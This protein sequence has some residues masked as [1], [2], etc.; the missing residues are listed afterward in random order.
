[1]RTW[2]E[3]E[4]LLKR[5]RDWLGRTD[6]EIQ[7][8]RDESDD[9]QD[10]SDGDLPEVGLVQLIEAF[11]ALR[12]EL[13]LQTKSS[14]GLEEAIEQAL[15]GIDEAAEQVRAFQARE[16]GEAERLARP[17]A[18]ALI[19]L[20]EALERGLRAA[21]SAQ[22]DVVQDAVGRF[23]QASQQ[24]LH[25][26]SAWQRWKARAWSDQ[27][28]ELFREQA[29]DLQRR[30]MLPLLEGYRLIYER[31]ERTLAEL[32]I[33]RIPCVGQSVD[34]M[35]MTVVELVDSA[36]A[37]PETVV[38]QVRPGYEWH[39]RLIRYAEVRAARRGDRRE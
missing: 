37:E 23:E 34:P 26:L 8:L 5:F 16:T 19:E 30:I 14:R 4:E 29:A 33:Q 15:A 36:G 7:S 25:Q 39:G 2:Y 27:A 18:E 35:R 22:R 10:A 1:M 20:D 9:L 6:A 24:R 38:D 28:S 31:L 3:N 32:G 21:E 13:K 17:L 11:T 12:Q